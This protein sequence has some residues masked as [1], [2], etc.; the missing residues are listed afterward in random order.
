MYT[1]KIYISQGKLT[2]T[3]GVYT[4]ITMMF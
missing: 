1:K 2:V 4:L 3:Y